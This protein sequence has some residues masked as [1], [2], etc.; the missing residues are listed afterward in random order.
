MSNARDYL[1]DS[2]VGKIFIELGRAWNAFKEQINYVEYNEEIDK[3]VSEEF[4]RVYNS[5]EAS[6]EQDELPNKLKDLRLDTE[7]IDNLNGVIEDYNKKPKQRD[8]GGIVREK[9]EK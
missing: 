6:Q 9:G 5:I 4:N 1:R 7:V 8:H 2:I 3:N